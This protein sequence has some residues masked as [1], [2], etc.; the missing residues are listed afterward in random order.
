M[1]PSSK[2]FPHSTLTAFVIGCR[3]CHNCCGTHSEKQLNLPV[4]GQTTVLDL[5]GFY[6]VL[7]IA[8]LSLKANLKHNAML[9]L[10][11]AKLCA[12][13]GVCVCFC[14]FCVFHPLPENLGC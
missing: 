8:D 1:P 3:S 7:C 5:Q 2:P 9:Q 11:V 12:H 10:L 13:V 6:L 14:F 4:L